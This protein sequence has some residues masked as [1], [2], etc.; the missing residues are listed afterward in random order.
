MSV[1]SII[2]ICYAVHWTDNKVDYEQPYCHGVWPSL[3]STGPKRPHLTIGS[4]VRPHE[5]RYKVSKV[6]QTF[7]RPPVFSCW[8]WLAWRHHGWRHGHPPPPPARIL[9]WISRRRAQLQP[10]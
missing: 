1:V 2:S 9:W 4:P 6:S 7:S 10:M 3:Y 5:V 8:T